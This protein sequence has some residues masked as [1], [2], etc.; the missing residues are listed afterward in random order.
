MQNVKKV[1]VAVIGVGSAGLYALGQVR[2]GT[3]DFLVIDDGPLGT[4][5]A[6][7][8]CMP[9]KVLIQVAEDFHRREVM[10]RE[11]IAGGDGLAVDPAAVLEHVRK[12]RDGFVGSIVPRIEALGD[13]LIR[14]S[15]R[16]VASNAVEVDGMRIEAERFVLA[17]GSR[18][19]VPP[20][21]RELG[22]AIL[23]TDT[24][25]EQPAWPRRIGVVGLG[26]IGLEL[27]QALAR[28]GAAVTGVDVLET[29]GGVSD[30]VVGGFMTEAAAEEF[31]L[32]LGAPAELSPADGGVCLRAGG[33]ETTV[34]RV[35]A[36][37]GRRSN[38]DRLDLAAAGVALDDRGMP[39][40]D[41]E[42][43]QIEGH[44]IFVAGDAT[45]DR[46]VLHEAADEGRIAGHNAVSDTPRRFRRKPPL[47]ITFTD[48]NIAVVGEEWR[49]LS[50]RP[51][52][53]VGTR[54]FAT[55]SRA[56][57]MGR[58]RGVLRLYGRKA[59]G[60]LLGA[61][62]AVPGGEHLA[63]LLAWA[64]Q[65]GRTA[66]DLLRY[67]FYHPVLEEGLQNALYDLAGQVEGKPP[68]PAEL[69]PVT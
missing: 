21:W 12:L 62:M 58:N 24:L 35:L 63:H 61:A 22:D 46:P 66:F 26:A 36:S 18:P 67:G 25:F 55:Q 16:F 19:V 43:M 27:G 28:L 56:V 65:D 17:V 23:T 30:P 47:A 69:V 10:A 57:A 49:A 34:D 2:K 6:R 13:R 3:E 8:G 20:A 42:T 9:S 4:T 37:L 53:V 32:W 33:R 38:L 39:S 52:V 31:P 51:D 1:Q 50:D 54:E 64:I 11:G 15:A 44:P 29:V 59:D 48:P 68:A 7:V 40:I 14:G 41:P 5:C 60:R 45:G